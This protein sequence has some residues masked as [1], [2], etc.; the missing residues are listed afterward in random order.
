MEIYE[1]IAEK[2]RKDEKIAVVTIVGAKG[3]SPR[4]VGSMMV[5]DIQGKL[6]SGTIGG[7][8]LEEKSKEE[9][10]LCI[11]KG[12][13]KLTS[14]SLD[15]EADG[16]NVLDMICGGEADVF[17]QVLS[18]QKKLL[19]IGG[20]H[21]GLVLYK[22]ASIVGFNVSVIDNRKEF[23]DKARFPSATVLHGDVKT[24]LKD[25]DID[26]N[27]SVVIVSHGH[28]SDEAALGCVVKKDAGYI[29]MIGSVEKNAQCF[30]HLL[31]KGITQRQLNKVYAPIGLDIG[32]DGPEEIALAIMAEIQAVG[33]DRNA[34]FLR[35]VE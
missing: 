9:A 24:I 5:V 34:G 3:S 10:R 16:E 29:G 28:R 6:L 13:S 22:L 20:G 4:G 8:L 31:E 11:K 14:Y 15:K 23:A 25:Y 19:I 35:S 27:T 7:G 30:G 21:I 18:K 17:I 32:G 1:L 26:I 33:Y 12:I 2:V